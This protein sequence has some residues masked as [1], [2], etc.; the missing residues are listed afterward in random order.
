MRGTI[1]ALVTVTVLQPV[2]LCCPAPQLLE[3]FV[4]TVLLP[5]YN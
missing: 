1:T 5:V 3:D 2:N 4:G